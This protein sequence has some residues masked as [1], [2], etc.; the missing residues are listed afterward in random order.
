MRAY[1]QLATAKDVETEL[2][3]KP[4][5]KTEFTDDGLCIF[6]M[7]V[8]PISDLKRRKVVYQELCTSHD[9]EINKER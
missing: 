5:E 8:I 2:N 6:W 7:S 9:H 3:C 4:K 1:L